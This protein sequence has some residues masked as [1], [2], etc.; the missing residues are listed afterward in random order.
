MG[1]SK[2]S[3]NINSVNKSIQEQ[4]EIIFNIN[5]ADKEYEK[6]SRNFKD[7][8]GFVSLKYLNQ[9]QSLIIL[10]DSIDQL[11]EDSHTLNWW[12][13]TLPKNVKIIYS[14]LNNY[15]KILENLK[16]KVHINNI[17]EMNLLNIDDKFSKSGGERLLNS[18]L[19]KANRQIT[20]K[21]NE[22]IIKLLNNLESISPLQIKLIFDITSKWN[23][24]FVPPDEFIKCKTSI[25]IIQYLFRIIEKEIFD[26]ETL[27]KRCIFYLT[28]FEYRGI[29][30][31]ELEDILS[32]DD[33]V[34]NSI[35]KHH[36][37][38]VRRFPI[39]LWYRIKYELKE[40]IINKVVDD[41]AV[42]CWL[43]LNKLF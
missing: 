23:S 33:C 2:S 39:A 16:K 21:Q 40:Y 17:F 6:N 7:L 18:F 34:L 37:P 20:Q 26:N 9:T 5:K 11:S 30:E 24:S 32:I 14:V 19:K 10:L 41:T 1:T 31:N 43:V 29:S 38:P 15:K 28:F 8:I 3:S 42:V 35:F 25:D 4:L 22:S 12:F 36:H 27:F 13:F